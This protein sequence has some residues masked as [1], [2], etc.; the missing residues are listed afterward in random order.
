MAYPQQF[1]LSR[2]TEECV[3]M[4]KKRHLRESS[5]QHYWSQNK[6]YLNTNH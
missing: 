4:C 1:T 6:N 5:Q 3:Y 2:F